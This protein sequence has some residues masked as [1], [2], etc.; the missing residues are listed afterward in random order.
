MTAKLFDRP[1]FA[2]YGA[3]WAARQRAFSERHDY[4]SGAVYM[5]EKMRFG[6]YLASRMYRGIKPL[7]LPF[8]RAVNVD[9]GIVPGNWRFKEDAPEAWRAARRQVWNWS[10]WSTEGVLF[11]HYGAIYGSSGLRVADLRDDRRVIISP[12]DPRCFM[13]AGRNEYDQKPEISFYIDSRK[14]DDGKPFE[15]AEVITGDQIQTFKDSE[16]AGFGGRK[17]EYDN[18]LG[19]VPVTEVQHVKTGDPFGA[20]TFIDGMRILDELNQLGSYLSDL[21]K[22]H[23]DPQWII[24]NA[25]KSDLNRGDNVWFVPGD[26]TDVKALVAML[27]ID[28]VRGFI[29]DLRDNVH[30]TL[31]ELAFD[32]LK[33][34]SQ[35]ATETLELRFH[36]LV[37][38]VK[39]CRPN[40]DSGVVQA[41]RMAGR[42]A[43]TLDLDAAAP[44]N[45]EKL[46]LD[47]ERPVLRAELDTRERIDYLLKTG[48]PSEGV[49]TLMGYDQAQIDEWNAIKDERAKQFNDQLDSDG[50][51]EL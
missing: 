42:A 50:E 49:W 33:A 43:E 51:S 1:E 36:E 20:C 18:K 35:I 22:K 11:V 4:Y 8:A 47:D 32:E 26:N 19:F 17:A 27:D 30:A 6:G 7:H 23:A 5:R 9:A 38:K 3:R 12:L 44:L 10:N 34:L 16:P 24:T 13:V 41:L 25:E 21:I 31:P 37:L 28:G 2:Q 46:E 48:A 45:D 39:R 40:Y 29:G 15:Y 14:D